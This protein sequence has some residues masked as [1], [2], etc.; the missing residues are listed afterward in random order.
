MIGDVASPARKRA[1]VQPLL[2]SRQRPAGLPD[3]ILTASSLTNVLRYA[4][5]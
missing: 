2:L 5:A 1:G 4:N 3:S